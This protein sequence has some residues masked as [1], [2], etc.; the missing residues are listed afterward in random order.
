MQFL[1]YAR[2]HYKLKKKQQIDLQWDLL[3]HSPF[4]KVVIANNVIT[5]N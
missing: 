5:A 1:L 2:E 4:I 3:W